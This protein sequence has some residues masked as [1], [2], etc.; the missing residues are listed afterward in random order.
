[1]APRPQF[2]YA[3]DK[4]MLK[5][6]FFFFWKLSSGTR[7]QSEEWEENGCDTQ[8]LKDANTLHASAL[9]RA[10]GKKK[11][12]QHRRLAQVFNSQI[13]S[14]I[15]KPPSCE[16]SLKS[17]SNEQGLITLLIPGSPDAE[18][19]QYIEGRERYHRS[20][21]L[22]FC[23]PRFRCITLIETNRG[24]SSAQRLSI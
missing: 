9:H 24:V 11:V 3:C 5:Y 21:P 17:T 7:L 20:L 6:L 1:M 4:Q 12:I 10:Q 13:T 14:G 22:V 15:N 18:H 23:L 2:A 16:S 8:S 19:Q